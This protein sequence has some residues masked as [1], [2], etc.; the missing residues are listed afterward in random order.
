[1]LILVFKLNTTEIEGGTCT[2]ILA[3]KPELDQSG[4][5]R[6]KREDIKII[7]NKSGMFAWT[8]L[9]WSRV[10]SNN[11]FCEHNDKIFKFNTRWK[12]S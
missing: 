2:Q 3:K 11:G 10:R 6:C 7:L 8:G 12:I 5:P 1:V 4:R 9:T